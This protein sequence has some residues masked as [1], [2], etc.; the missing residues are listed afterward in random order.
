MERIN[1]TEILQKKIQLMKQAKAEGRFEQIKGLF[2]YCDLD[3]SS[4]VGTFQSVYDEA[5]AFEGSSEELYKA[6][7]R[8]FIDHG[9][10]KG[11]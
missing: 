11:K 1:H 10:I 3:V 8:W 5:F 9:K 2:S 4:L 7:Q 6:M